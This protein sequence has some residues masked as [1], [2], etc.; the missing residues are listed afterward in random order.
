[1]PAAGASCWCCWSAWCIWCGCTASCS[2][3]GGP[4][5]RCRSRLEPCVAGDSA[6]AA[7]D[8]TAT[9]GGCPAAAAPGPLRLAPRTAAAAHSAGAGLLCPTVMS[10]RTRQQQGIG[11]AAGRRT[12]GKRAW[13]SRSSRSYRSRSCRQEH[14]RS[15]GR[16]WQTQ[17]NLAS[18]RKLF[19][20]RFRV[21]GL[22]SLIV[23]AAAGGQPASR[24]KPLRAPGGL[25]PCNQ[26]STGA[27]ATC[28]ARELVVRLPLVRRQ[29]R[30]LLAHQLRATRGRRGRRVGS[31]PATPGA[32][33]TGRRVP[34]LARPQHTSAAL[35]L[36]PHWLAASLLVRR[37]RG[38]P[39]WGPPC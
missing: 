23:A 39:P 28:L 36:G 22:G 1:M 34:P 37:G 10:T 25:C 17:A 24:H 12:W 29:L 20:L 6:M 13:Y 27:A 3:A 4:A 2:A 7:F 8:G 18:R 21:L 26:R 30:P 5:W 32:E 19:F 16:C 38:H 11:G 15:R 35:S 31:A 33:W 14:A 9:P